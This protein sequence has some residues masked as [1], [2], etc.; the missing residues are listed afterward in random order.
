[1]KDGLRKS[2]QWVFYS[3]FYKEWNS[4]V[5]QKKVQSYKVIMV[6]TLKKQT[7][8]PYSSVVVSFVPMKVEF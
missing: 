7:C 3:N 2:L 6:Y 5:I 8:W 1:M 4:V